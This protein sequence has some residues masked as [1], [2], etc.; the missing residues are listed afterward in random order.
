MDNIA[1]LFQL[2]KKH[3]KDYG[4]R[5]AIENPAYVYDHILYTE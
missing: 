5:F 3:V 1:F 4:R 2:A